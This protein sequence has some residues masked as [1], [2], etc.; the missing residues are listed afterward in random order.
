MTLLDERDRAFGILRIVVEW[1]KAKQQIRG[2]ALVGSY[3]RNQA[4]PGSDIDL[5]L[6]TEDP[7]DFRNTA[8]LTTIDWPGAGVYPTRWADEEYGAVRCHRLS[9]TSNSKLPLL[10]YS[11]RKCRLLTKELSGLCPMA[12]AFCTIQTDY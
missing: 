3:A 12:A 9:L 8:S 6:L 1:A 10:L 2:V 5:V 11:G 7:N 4:R